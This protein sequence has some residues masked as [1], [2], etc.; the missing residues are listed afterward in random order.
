MDK[1]ENKIA[2]LIKVLLK[3]SDVT[4]RVLA[5][6]AIAVLS[7]SSFINRYKNPIDSSY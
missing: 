2:E 4:A 5:L 1:N 3:H 7:K 6:I